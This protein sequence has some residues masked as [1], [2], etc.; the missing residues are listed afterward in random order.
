M[1]SAS[2]LLPGG[3]V[4]MPRSNVRGWLLGALL[5]GLPFVVYFPSLRGAYV[6]D[7]D[8]YVTQNR[9]LRSVDGLRRIW[10]EIGAEP[11]YYTV[12]YS[13]FWVEYHLWGLAPLG[14]HLVNISLHSLGVLL[15]WRLLVRLRVP[16]GWFATAIF[17]VHPVCVESIAWITERKNTL[18]LFFALASML[19]Y[20]RFEPPEIAAQEVESGK[21][22]WGSYAAAPRSVRVGTAEQNRGRRLAGSPGG[23]LL[24]EKWIDPL[25][26]HGAVGAD[27]FVG[28]RVG[29]HHNLG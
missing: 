27:V 28:H 6:L 22:R 10:F 21:R 17:A 5:C 24:V 16:G 26:N 13:T 9:T 11:D 7:D 20:L 18:S 4:E 25:A 1:I 8:I 2:E 12:V 23:A 19:C 3:A 15:L 14:Y 29:K